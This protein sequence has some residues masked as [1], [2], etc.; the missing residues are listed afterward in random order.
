MRDINQIESV[1]VSMSIA[2]PRL[3]DFHA[4]LFRKK[5]NV[6]R[7]SKVD[8]TRYERSKSMNDVLRPIDILSII[9]GLRFL[10]FSRGH[11][12][13]I[14]NFFYSMLLCCL[15]FTSRFYWSDN[16]LIDVH[17]TIFHITSTV[18]F[19]VIVTIL[20][21]GLYRRE[22]LKLCAKKIDEID[23]TLQAL[24]SSAYFNNIYNRTIRDITI[25]IIYLFFSFTIKI[26]GQILK[27]WPFIKSLKICSYI[28]LHTYSFMV[29]FLLVIEFLTIVRCIKS[30]F[31]RANELLA[32]V[33]VLPISSIA[34]ELFEHREADGSFSIERVLPVNSKKLFIVAPSLRQRQSQLQISSHK[35]NR[36]KMLLRTIR[37]IHLELYRVSDNLSNMYGIQISL[38]MAM[39]VMLNT[40]VLYNFYVKT[41][42]LFLQHSTKIFFVNYFCDKTTK[43]A[44][45]TNEIIHTFYGQNTDFEIQEEVEVFSLQMMRHHNTYTAFGLYNLN[46]KHICSCIAIITTYM[47]IMIQVTDSKV[48]IYKWV[49]SND[50]IK[51]K[52][53]SHLSERK[54]K[55]DYEM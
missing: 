7:I 34:S 4:L 39:C 46:C 6:Q 12:R 24:G 49:S 37:Q 42:L 27:D 36:S 38:E 29:E 50:R 53:S 43:E 8:K 32:D 47:V 5:E 55:Y 51:E 41:L 11:S 17:E 45:R 10:R 48:N 19:I 26:V 33:N 13:S 54:Y 31:Q 16:R 1:L 21:I 23:K 18:H 20:I 2:A 15:Y 30:E 25:I 52:D 35:I 28:F 40:Y 14:L 22:A 3:R 44:D 9:F